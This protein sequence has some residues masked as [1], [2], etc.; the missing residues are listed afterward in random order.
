MFNEAKDE[1]A[2]IVK[3]CISLNKCL[4][5][6][7]LVGLWSL[8]FTMQNYG[9]HNYRQILLFVY[10]VSGNMNSVCFI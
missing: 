5:M 6:M 10:V 8:L 4:P 2:G 9:F 7:V 3:K 1:G